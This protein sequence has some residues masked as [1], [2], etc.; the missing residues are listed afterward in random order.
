[1]INPVEYGNYYHSWENVDVIYWN[2][3]CIATSIFLCLYWNLNCM[4]TSHFNRMRKCGF[5]GALSYVTAWCFCM[6]Y[7]IGSKTTRHMRNA[8]RIFTM[9]NGTRSIQLHMQFKQHIK[10]PRYS[11]IF[12]SSFHIFFHLSKYFLLS[13]PLF[14]DSLCNYNLGLNL[15]MFLGVSLACTNQ[16]GYESGENCPNHF[17][18]SWF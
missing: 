9:W 17:E 13:F 12:L 4:K 5:A 10:R 2:L 7:L 3:K 18:F 15:H 11:S 6:S 16:D 14:L 1:M 8:F